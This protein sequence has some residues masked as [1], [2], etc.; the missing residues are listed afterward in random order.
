V[1]PIQ[2]V[3]LI[4]AARS[5]TRLIRDLI[6]LHP[7]IDRVPYDVNYIWR[8]G[9]E[10]LPHDALAVDDL[11]SKIQ[12]RIK[13]RI[14]GFSKGSPFLIEKTVSN[15]LRIP[16]VEAVFPQAVYIHLFRNGWDVTES[17]YRKWSSPRSWNYILKK[18]L[19]YPLLD[20]PGYAFDYA[21]TVLKQSLGLADPRRGTWGPRYPGIQNDMINR[22]LL[23][24]CAIQWASSVNYALDGINQVHPKRVI[25]IRYEMFVRQPLQHLEDIAGFLG[26]DGGLYAQLLEPS[27]VTFA[28]VGKGKRSLTAEQ[29]I[30]V[31]PHIQSTLELLEYS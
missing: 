9:N 23:E 16:F 20:A 26:I 24:V 27:R 29:Q 12:A 17:A 6:A 22:S 31:A 28:Y 25:T 5:G 3:F 21:N 18:A 14:Q 8:L 13:K 7:Q 4:G 15:S 10:K 1:F 2:P 19:Q 30:M 11:T